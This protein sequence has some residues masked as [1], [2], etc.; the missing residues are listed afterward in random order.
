MTKSAVFV[1]TPL[2]TMTLVE[3]NGALNA[4]RFTQWTQPCEQLTK[5]PLLQ[6]AEEELLEYFAGQ[7]TAFTVPMAPEGTPFQQAVWEALLTI[8]YGETRTYGEIAKQ[9]GNPK[10]SRAVGMA[11]HQNPLAIFYPCH[12]VIGAGGKLTGYGGGLPVKAFLL[13][14]ENALPPANAGKKGSPT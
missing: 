6:K 8:P 3:G 4:L 12:R 11:N 2:G 5:T 1:Q 10:A 7:R 14:L 13:T 9:V